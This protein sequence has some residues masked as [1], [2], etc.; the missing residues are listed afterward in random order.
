MMHRVYNAL[1]SLCLRIDHVGTV[2]LKDRNKWLSSIKKVASEVETEKHC[3]KFDE[4]GVK[5][6]FDNFES[7]LKSSD[8]EG[9]I[10]EV[11]SVFLPI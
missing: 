6:F 2:L 7:L 5:S 3:V 10:D 9:L 11:L 8:F 4:L 1:A